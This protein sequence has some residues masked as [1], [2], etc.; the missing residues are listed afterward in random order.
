M[1]R[2]KNLHRHD[3]AAIVFGGPSLLEQELDF[4][5]LR[6]KNL[7]IFLEAQA[8]TRWFLACGVQ[9][10]YYLMP[11]PE[12]CHGNSLHN[13]IFRGFLAQV[14]PRWFLKRTRLPVLRDMKANFVR[15]FEPWRPHRGPHK[16]LRWKPGVFLQDSPY[17]L[18]R[19]LGSQV[20]IIANKKLL[21]AHF[22][23]GVDRDGLHLFAQSI[24]QE[25]FNL[26]RYYNPDDSGDLLTLRPVPF[27][28]SAAITLYP[29]LHYMGFKE[30]FFFGM[31]MSMLGSF[32]HAA[33]HIF[34]TMWHFR[35]FFRRT[36][37][38]FNA[39]Y[40]RNR[41]YYLRPP[42]EFDDIKQ[43]LDYHGLSFTRVCDP[44]TWAA[45]VTQGL[46]TISFREFL[47]Q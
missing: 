29:L 43:L 41:P 32:E 42:C 37:R 15:Y 18:I 8:L 40:V 3:R 2:L 46:R 38:A 20:N 19:D 22:P 10:D 24:E 45:P 12:K 47:R 28:N 21:D 9:P 1:K 23:R 25:Q 26:D 17:D 33:P 31:D 14:E 39:N 36:R 27:V 13:F 34:K 30:V 6:D 7:V 16:R 4:Q 11:F 35:A 44:F 5:K